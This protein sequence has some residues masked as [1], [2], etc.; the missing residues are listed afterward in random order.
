MQLSLIREKQMNMENPN[1][2]SFTVIANL[3][4]ELIY[5]K[6]Q[7]SYKNFHRDDPTRQ[8]LVVSLAKETAKWESQVQI[9]KEHK[10]TIEYSKHA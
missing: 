6:S 7:N 10:K 4:I 8:L 9:E 3:I 5:S 1:E 2:N